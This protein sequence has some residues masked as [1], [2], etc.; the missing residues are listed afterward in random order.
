M[1]NKHG[2]SQNF[3]LAEEEEDLKGIVLSFPLLSNS[4]KIRLTE[5]TL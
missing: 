4:L 3:L 2:I 1:H 5:E